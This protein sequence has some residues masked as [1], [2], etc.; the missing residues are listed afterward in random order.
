MIIGEGMS[1]LEKD[2]FTEMLYNREAVLAWDFTEM[3]KFKKEEAAAQKIWT[4]EHKT[5]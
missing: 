5:W 1:P 4:V 2:V 3:G